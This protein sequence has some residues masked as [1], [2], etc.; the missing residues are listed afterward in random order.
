MNSYP[1]AEPHR[2]DNNSI[3]GVRHA[4]AYGSF[5]ALADRKRA[6]LASQGSDVMPVPTDD[7]TRHIGGS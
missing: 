5:V 4:D 6:V 3:A 7:P 1:K 2:T